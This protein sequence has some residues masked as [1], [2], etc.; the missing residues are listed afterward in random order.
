MSILHVVEHTYVTKNL[1]APLHRL[2]MV[3]QLL[4]GDSVVKEPVR[5]LAAFLQ[6]L[7][8]N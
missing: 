1:P 7:W 2:S 8:L 4:N 6:L 5:R 3:R